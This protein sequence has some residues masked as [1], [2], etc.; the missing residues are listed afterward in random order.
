[1]LHLI[2]SF[3]NRITM[4]RLVLYGL[5]ILAAYTVFMGLSGFISF[6]A[7]QLLFSGTILFIT[8]Y[9]TNYLLAKTVT[10]PTNV[11]SSTITSLILFFILSPFS[12]THQIATLV[13]AGVIAMTSKYLLA[14]HKKHLFNP[15][16][17]VIILVFPPKRITGTRF[18]FDVIPPLVLS[19]F[20][21]RP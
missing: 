13:L 1:M 18:R 8:C 21:V 6:T 12:E 3:L 19:T 11:E 14:I 2:D 17:I 10:A 15:A 9:V 16:A 20:R 7:T 5:L 4:Y